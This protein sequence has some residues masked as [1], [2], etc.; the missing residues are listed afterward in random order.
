ET[1]MN[2]LANSINPDGIRAREVVESLDKDIVDELGHAKQFG[3]RIKE[4]YGVVPTSVDF[5]PE[6]P[7][8][9]PPDKQTDLVHVIKGVVAAEQ[10][11]IALYTKIVEFCDDGDL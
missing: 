5:K 4:L 9:R 6:Q 2:Y 10:D 8:L 1:V 7:Y 11:A 3:N